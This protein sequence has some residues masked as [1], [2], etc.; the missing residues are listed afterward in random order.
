MFEKYDDKSIARYLSDNLSKRE[1]KEI[2][3]RI[4][5][6]PEFA[7]FISLMKSTWNAKQKDIKIKDLDLKWIQMRNRVEGELLDKQ[8]ESELNRKWGK[9]YT[10]PAWFSNIRLVPVVAVCLT[11][12]IGSFYF[13]KQIIYNNSQQVAVMP[14]FE[15]IE[16]AHGERAR[17]ELADGTRIL[18]DAG[19]KLTYPVQFSKKRREVTLEGEGFFEVERDES[20]P[21]IVNARHAEIQVLGTKFNVRA[22]EES[23]LITVAVKEG[24]V[25]LAQADDSTRQHVLIGGGKQ[26]QLSEEGKL[27]EV[28]STNVEQHTA[29]MNNEIR[30]KNVRLHE[31]LAQLTRWYDFE[32]HV[33]DSHLLETPITVHIRKTNIDDVFELIGMITHTKVERD[34]NIIHMMNE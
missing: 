13:T 1:K 27:S 29:W 8:R 26:S 4:K 7:Q 33:Q 25:S 23:E 17:I 11:V 34:S 20:R 14:E 15:T 16:V 9:R 32:F 30:M 12:L 31:V 22:W 28:T 19:S 10:Q 3:A 5:Q 18:L 6:D 21:F 24:L 2:E